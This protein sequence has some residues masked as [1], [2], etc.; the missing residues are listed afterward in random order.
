[1]KKLFN[2]TIF[3]SYLFILFFILINTYLIFKADSSKLFETF[4]MF[5]G[6]W[7]F[8]IVLLKI[9]SNHIEI[10]EDTNV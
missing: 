9:I 10:E 4:I 6:V 7:L 3:L 1:M 5:Y 2:S 8:M